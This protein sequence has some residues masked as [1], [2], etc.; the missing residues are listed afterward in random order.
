VAWQAPAS[1][2]GT[3]PFQ[4]GDAGVVANAHAQDPFYDTTVTASTTT[5]VH[6]K[7][8]LRQG[9]PGVRS[10]SDPDLVARQ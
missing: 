1:P 2:G 5:V 9:R 3:T 6:L 4:K 10:R 8:G 7:K